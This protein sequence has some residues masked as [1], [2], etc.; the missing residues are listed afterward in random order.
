MNMKYVY[1][2]VRNDLDYFYFLGAFA[3]LR[4]VAISS[5]MYLCKSFRPSVRMEQRG[6]HWT[7]FHET[8]Y[9]NIFRKICPGDSSFI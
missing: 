8:W 4:K 2:A 9:Y 5:V 1:C 7:N 3:K 6:S